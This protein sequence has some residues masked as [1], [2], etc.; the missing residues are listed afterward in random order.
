MISFAKKKPTKQQQPQL[1]N[2][3]KTLS[4]FVDCAIYQG[5]TFLASVAL[6]L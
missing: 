1:K 3:S 6:P 5:F 2:S 4:A